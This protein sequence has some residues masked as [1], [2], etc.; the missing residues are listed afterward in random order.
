MPKLVNDVQRFVMWPKKFRHPN[1][2]WTWIAIMNSQ[3]DT[4]ILVFG[5]LPTRPMFII[6][7]LINAYR[8]ISNKLVSLIKVETVYSIRT[9]CFI[10][11]REIFANRIFHKSSATTG[12]DYTSSFIRKLRRKI[13][14]T[15][16]R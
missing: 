12:D 5:I 13:S 16:R 9:V 14:I 11:H 7:L 10:Q 2:I 3:Y 4:L 1:S 6:K 15:D 8:L